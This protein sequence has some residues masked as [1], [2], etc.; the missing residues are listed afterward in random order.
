MIFPFTIKYSVHLDNYYAI[1]RSKETL[2]IIQEFI[3]QKTGEDIIIRDNKLTFKSKFFK[4]GRLN[5]NVLVPIE[6][7]VFTII[8]KDRRPILTYEFYMYRLFIVVTIMSAFGAIADQ[9]VW[10]GILCFLWVGGMNWLT[11]IIR[12]KMMLNEIAKEI[13]N[14]INKTEEDGQKGSL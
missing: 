3:T 4:S 14:F 6:K 9:Q 2:E 13:D 8:E 1:E 10:S 7:G 12:H 5:T 11:A